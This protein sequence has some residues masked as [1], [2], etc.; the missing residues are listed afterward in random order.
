MQSTSEILPKLL[1]A[2]KQ[3]SET[4]F[5]TELEGIC[6]IAGDALKRYTYHF[7]N[8]FGEKSLGFSITSLK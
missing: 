8:F 3:P 2:T 1:V 5:E 7:G 6:F 4:V